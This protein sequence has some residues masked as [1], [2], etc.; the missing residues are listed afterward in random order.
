MPS[1]GSE[2]LREGIRLTSKQRFDQACG[3]RTRPEPTSSG[4][5]L[6]TSVSKLAVP[7]SLACNVCGFS[8]PFVASFSAHSA[9]TPAACGV[10][11]L[12]PL[13]DRSPPPVWR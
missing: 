4:S 3:A 13:R 6:L 5:M 12:V 2:E 1:R 8:R 11:I 10:A 9:A 7:R